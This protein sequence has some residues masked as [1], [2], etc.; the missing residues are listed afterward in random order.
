MT[1][2]Q[3]Y[4]MREIGSAMEAGAQ[5]IVR[6]SGPDVPEDR[7]AGKSVWPGGGDG[8]LDPKEARGRA[9]A[10]GNAVGHGPRSAHGGNAG[11]CGCRS[12]RHSVWCLLNAAGDFREKDATVSF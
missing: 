11:F 10:P 8:I 2:A 12:G 5:K 4:P 1:D 7:E 9:F 3:T 6:G